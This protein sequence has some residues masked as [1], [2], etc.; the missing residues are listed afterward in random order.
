MKDEG[1]RATLNKMLETLPQKPRNR[2]GQR[3]YCSV[4]I[5]GLKEKP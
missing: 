4:R 1:T 2:A 3:G 5:F